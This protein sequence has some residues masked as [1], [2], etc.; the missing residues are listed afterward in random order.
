MV[1]ANRL[2]VVVVNDDELVLGGLRRDLRST[3]AS[4]RCARS[5]RGALELVSRD[6]PDLLL[7]A[8]DIPGDMDALA[9]LKRVRAEHP[10]VRCWLH[11]REHSDLTRLASFQVVSMSCG[12]MVLRSLIESVQ[13]QPP[14]QAGMGPSRPE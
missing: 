9:L 1:G 2:S 13:Q 7:C 6:P 10:E 4:I 8:A 12:P 5:T 14:G 11:T 3:G